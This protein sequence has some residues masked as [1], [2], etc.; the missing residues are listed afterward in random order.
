MNDE[1]TNQLFTDQTVRRELARQSH[2]L[3]FHMYFN[4]YVKYP[5]ADFHKTIFKLTEK[6]SAPEVFIMAFRGSAKTTILSNSFP[7][8]AII[9][10]QQ[11]RFVVIV[12]Q[13]QSQSRQILNNIR[14]ELE[15]ND[16]LKKDFGPFTDGKGE[17]STSSLELTKYGARIMAVSTGESIRGLRHGSFRPDLI[18]LDDVEDINSVKT[19][20]NRQNIYRWFTSEI[21][22]LGDIGTRIVVAGNLLHE[23]SLMMKLKEYDNMVGMNSVFVSFPLVNEDG[24]IL[25]PQKYTP[26]KIEEM[27]REMID[28]GS[29]EREYLLQIVPDEQQVIQRE[30]IK[31]Y[32]L[33]LPAREIQKPRMIIIAIDLAI[34]K[35]D[36]RD[37]TAMVPFY[38]AGFDKTLEAYV[39]P[40]IINKQLDFPE[41]VVEIKKLH[42]ELQQTFSIIPRIFVESVGYQDAVVQQLF[43]VE[44]IMA[45]PVSVGNLDKA[46]R[47]RLVSP[48]VQLGKVSFPEFG[49]EMLINQLLNIHSTKHDDLADAF[50]IGLSK[51]IE[52]DQPHYPFK[53]TEDKPHYAYDNITGEWRDIS[54]PYTAGMLD[55]KY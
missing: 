26:E 16:L 45:E 38:L 30:W 41:T 51:I 46:S 8:W 4:E 37:F 19:F 9:G 10:K 55:M 40:R 48:Y 43:L 42:A 33:V 39:L 24:E 50:T 21:K 47:L 20:D 7:I 35:G 36:G 23:D 2:I 1:L 15:S 29:F 32:K 44:K 22:P 17:W 53:M 34:K 49:A 11:K 25:W 52:S 31:K 13:T 54:K 6:T 12:S 28:S 14:R 5:T 18:I 27:R 3:F